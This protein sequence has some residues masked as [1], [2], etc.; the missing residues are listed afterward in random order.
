MRRFIAMP[1]NTPNAHYVEYSRV[2]CI[3]LEISVVV[4]FGF[5]IYGINYATHFDYS[6]H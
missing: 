2:Y 4:V 1:S 5:K 6:T 3:L